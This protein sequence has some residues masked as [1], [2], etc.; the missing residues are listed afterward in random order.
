[1]KHAVYIIC[2]E[3]KTDPRFPGNLVLR[4]TVFWETPQEAREELE[5]YELKYPD[6]KVIR[7]AL[8]VP[9]TTLTTK[10]EYKPKGEGY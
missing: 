3:R 8:F 4:S 7:L 9:Q 10:L 6:W 1:M 5:K 2:S